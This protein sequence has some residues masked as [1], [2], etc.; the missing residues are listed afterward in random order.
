[1]RMIELFN[2]GI[3]GD[4]LCDANGNIKSLGLYLALLALGAIIA[5]LLGSFSSAVVISRIFFHDD[6]RRH[7][8]GNAGATN[9]LR[10]FGKRAALLT[11]ILDVLK[12]C[13]A[14]GVSFLL[15]GGY[16]IGGFSFSRAAFVAALACILGHIYPLYHGF[17]GGKGV[18]CAITV[19][20]FL[21]PLMVPLLLVIFAFTVAC[22][23]YVSL[24]SILSALCYPLFYPLIFKVS[25]VGLNPPYLTMLLVPLVIAGV[26]VYKHKGNIVRLRNHEERCISFN[27][28]IEVITEIADPACD[29]EDQL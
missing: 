18:L 1:M 10:T 20:G 16:W 8:S 2:Y 21:S 17:R 23:R 28:P 14:M 24:G 12:S 29:E 15:T 27:D 13:L 25:F 3:F 5:Y 26:I 7:G 6:V 9:M 4:R 19:I 11:L 22:S